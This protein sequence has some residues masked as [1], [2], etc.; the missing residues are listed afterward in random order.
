MLIQHEETGNISEI[1]DNA[2]IPPRWFRIAEAA[3][4]ETVKLSSFVCP[5]CKSN[6]WAEVYPS[7]SDPT[8][9]T[10]YCRRCEEGCVTPLK[11]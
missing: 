5:T 8:G 10:L 4:V 2:T 9:F 1:A 6:R 3:R 7:K 11:T